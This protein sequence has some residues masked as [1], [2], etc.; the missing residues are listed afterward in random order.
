M[1][2][3]P[4][5]RRNLWLFAALC[6]A[7]LVVA[8]VYVYMARGRVQ[9]DA[10]LG[11]DPSVRAANPDVVANVRRGPHIA[12]RSLVPGD[13]YGVLSFAPLDA[14]TGPR[15]MTNLRCLR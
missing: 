12:F 9:A 10:G 5:R 2:M 7:S 8:V 6:A 3:P 4:E 11:G 1:S 15:E 14:P 13:D